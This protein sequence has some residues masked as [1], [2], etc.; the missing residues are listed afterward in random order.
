MEIR[1]SKYSFLLLTQNRNDNL[2]PGLGFRVWTRKSTLILKTQ[3]LSY[4]MIIDHYCRQTARK[5]TCQPALSPCPHTQSVTL[6][7]L[8]PVFLHVPP[9]NTIFSFPPNGSLWSL[10]ET[11]KGACSRNVLMFIQST[12]TQAYLLGYTQASVTSAGGAQTFLMPSIWRILLHTAKDV[13]PVITISSS[14][15]L[16]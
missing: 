3:L 9:T 10:Q 5:Y 4:Y 12:Q 1:T 14:S 15:T 6:Q 7:P 8:G 13:H 16:D 11:T 2:N